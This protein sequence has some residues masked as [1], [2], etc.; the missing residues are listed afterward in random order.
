MSFS[1]YSFPV[2]DT[3]LTSCR[4]LLC[5]PLFNSESIYLS[6]PISLFQQSSLL[7]HRQQITRSPLQHLFFP[8]IKNAFMLFFPFLCTAYSGSHLQTTLECYLHCPGLGS[9]YSFPLP[10]EDVCSDLNFS[11]VQGCLESRLLAWVPLGASCQHLGV[12]RSCLRAGKPGL[13]DEHYKESRKK[14]PSSFTGKLKL[15]LHW[16]IWLLQHFSF[17]TQIIS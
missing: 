5:Q 2:F 10:T 13:Q 1:F 8:H 15:T 17:S 7:S 6:N 4:A 16:I 12:D 14:N 11:R 3:S 9:H